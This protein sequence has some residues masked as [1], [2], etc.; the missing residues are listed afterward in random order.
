MK[1][2]WELF[3]TFMRIGAFTFG[4]GFAMIPLI[5][6][7]IVDKKK[8]VSSEDILNLFAVSQ[9]VPGAVAINTSTLV[10]YKIAGRLGG[11]FA[12]I[13]VIVPS[14]VIISV[15]A[16]FFGTMDAKTA[17]PYFLGIN[18]AVFALIC[19]ALVRM[20]KAAV[21][22]KTTVV[23]YLI[24]LFIIVSG[25]ISPIFVIL[26]SVL[27]GLIFW[28]INPEK[29]MNLLVNNKMKGEEKA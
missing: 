9:S 29:A 15:I 14:F 2:Y 24:A 17:E 19:M 21:Y 13:G 22:N 16:A 7:E 23:I 28:K 3:L 25:T 6:R 26:F 1:I 12:T 20:F 4:G 5:E 11:I 8:W 27:P 10:G 18:G